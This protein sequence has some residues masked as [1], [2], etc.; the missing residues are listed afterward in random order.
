MNKII[1]SR[2]PLRLGLAGGGTDVSPYTELHGGV[3]VNSTINLYAHASIEPTEVGKI[4]VLSVDLNKKSAI[5]SDKKI[6]LPVELRLI[7]GVYNRIVND[8]VKKPLSFRITTKVDAV[9][10]SGLGSSSTL[11]V[12]MVGAFTEW[13]NIPLGE[14]DIAKL[15]YEIERVDLKMSGGKQDQ[16]AATFG[17]FNLMEF[18]EGDHVIINPLRIKPRFINELENNLVIYYTGQSRYS[19]KIIDAQS[20]GVE[21]KV[22]RSINALH[23]LKLQA[24]TMKEALL[25]GKIDEIGEIMGAGW[26]HKKR[27]SDAVSNEI[28][29]NIYETALLAGATGGKV[30][31]A[32]GGGFIMFY[33]PGN[34]RH[35]VGK[36]LKEEFGGQFQNFSF[37]NRGLEVWNVF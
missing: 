2:A 3:V 7:Q 12:A 25:K 33:C 24:E 34:S 18:Y 22:E 37:T 8:Y 13:L 11:V 36:K 20:K 14:Y 21:N 19:S 35:N 17:G 15:A 23:G 5:P 4:E 31:G 9:P 26:E 10:G 6:Q 1:R 30:S 28:I 27:T 29:D 16:Y 32:G